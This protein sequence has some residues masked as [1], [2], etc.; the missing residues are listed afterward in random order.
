MYLLQ[1]RVLET[2][3]SRFEASH[4]GQTDSRHRG[5]GQASARQPKH[6]VTSLS[7]QPENL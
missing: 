4:S 2:V 7:C 5:L 3:E 1:G 6:H